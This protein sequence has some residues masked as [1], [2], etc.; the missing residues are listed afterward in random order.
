MSIATHKEN[1]NLEAVHPT[2]DPTLEQFQEVFQHPQGLPPLRTNSHHIL[3]AP[4]SE[5]VNAYLYRYLYFQKNEIE[6]F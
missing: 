4:Q 6:N 1:T 3:L 2:I 5:P